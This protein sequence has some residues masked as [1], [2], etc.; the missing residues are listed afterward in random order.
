MV[1]NKEHNIRRVA[2]HSLARRLSCISNK[3]YRRTRHARTDEAGDFVDVKADERKEE[4]GPS[5]QLNVHA[6]KTREK[7]SRTGENLGKEVES[8]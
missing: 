6:A 7:T 3:S 4:N 1:R 5:E 2:K 8:T